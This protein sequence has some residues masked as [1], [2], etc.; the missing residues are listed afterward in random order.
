MNALP[1]LKRSFTLVKVPYGSN[2]ALRDSSVVSKESPWAKSSHFPSCSSETAGVSSTAMD[3]FLEDFLDFGF[4]SSISAS[5]SDPELDESFLE[6]FFFGAGLSESE[7]DPDE[8]PESDEESFLA[9]FFAGAF[10]AGFSL[11]SESEESEEESF[12]AA[13]FLAGAFL[14]GFSLSEE[15][16]SEEESFLAAAFLVGAFL[17][18]LS[19]SEESESEDESFLAAFLTGAAFFPLTTSTSDS[20]SD[21]E[22]EESSTLDFLTGT[23][24]FSEVFLDLFF[25]DEAFDLA[26]T[27]DPAL[28]LLAR[29]FFGALSELE[30][31]PLLE[32]E[33]DAFLAGF[34]STFFLV[35]SIDCFLDG[36]SDDDAEAFLT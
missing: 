29:T 4:S 5:E 31:E 30:E 32:L 2:M 13:A 12:L 6:A 36:A 23:V 18:G 24:A 11:S 20:E 33:L 21:P 9:A 3:A 16:E 17:A 22:E 7:S 15:S 28:V 14:A 27:L 1:L 26:E 25:C 34:F 10:F 8:D 35:L 19:L